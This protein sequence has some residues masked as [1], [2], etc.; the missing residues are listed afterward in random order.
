MINNC[1]TDIYAGLLPDKRLEKRVV[2]SMMDL[3]NLG[4]AVVNKASKAHSNKIGFY[5]MLSN[6]SFSY[7]DLLEGSFRKCVESI[8][9]SHVLAIQDTTEFNYNGLKGKLSKEDPD[10]G[11]TTRKAIPGYFCHPVL[12]VGANSPSIFGLS[13][14]LIYNRQWDQKNKYERNY[15]DQ[16]IEQK[17][18]Y[19]WIEAAEQT[20]ERIPP[21]VM[22]TIIGDRENDIY[23]DFVRVPDNRTH[24]LV[25]SRTDRMIANKGGK[26]YA[27]LENQAVQGRV[28]VEVSSSKNRE[29]RSA[30]LT[31]KFCP[32]TISA[33]ADYKGD[34]KSVDLYAIEA[35]EEEHTVPKG[36]SPILWRLLTT[37]KVESFED[38]LQCV[39]WYKKRWLIEELFR[40][41]KTKGFRIESSQLGSGQGLK[42]LLAIT[43][44]AAL[45]VMRLKMALKK[46]TA[47]ASEIF[48][49]KQQ[50]FLEV[51]Q[52]KVEGDTE[53]QKNPYRKQSLAWAAWT[54]ARLAGWSGYKSHGPPGYITIKEGY[55]YF[56]IQFEV[57]DM[58]VDDQ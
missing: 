58:L 46:E 26:L 1:F 42:K 5:R 56:N 45:H 23:E 40:V 30:E 13:S 41:I 6:D 28:L 20:K 24:I 44:E 50:Q 8:N 53:K 38:S 12:V 31:L 51:L 17:E 14:A 57:Y 48:T 10:I 52:K 22:I 21:N 27:T 34:K 54:L 2:K 33:P 39:E 18:S 36:E 9:S 11:P 16:P 15:H 35:R 49:P 32:V 37:H 3:L 55:D 4:T 7:N 25:R 47:E 43:L 29:K 19:R